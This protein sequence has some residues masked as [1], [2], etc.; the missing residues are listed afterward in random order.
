MIR[1][2]DLDMVRCPDCLEPVTFS[3]RM[4]RDHLEKGTLR[5]AG[6]GS[7]WPVLDGLP[8]LFREERVKGNDRLL[9][10]VYDAFARLHDPAVRHVL[11]LLESGS[12]KALRDGYMRRLELGSLQPRPDG[13]PYRILEVGIGGGANL[14]LIR[15]DLAPGVPVE[16]WGVDLSLGMLSECR[17]V[18]PGAGLGHVRLM[19]SDAHALPFPD[20]A[21]DRVFHVGGIGGFRDPAKAL[22]EMARVARPGTPIVVVDEQLDA[23]RVNTLYHRVMFRLLTLYDPQPHCP[24]ECL[25]AGAAEVIEEQVSRFY[26]C[27]T[28]LVPP[29]PNSR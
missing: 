4:D 14:P 22:A 9:R 2:G 15:R 20:A 23:D 7:V 16:V 19:M 28:F 11:P 29:A 1:T 8:R 3:G 17:K 26:Y 13:R 12:E 6:C 25:P 24:S 10:Y 21:F 5:C 18:I 27:L